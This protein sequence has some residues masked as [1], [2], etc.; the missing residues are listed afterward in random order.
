MPSATHLLRLGPPALHAGQQAGTGGARQPVAG[1]VGVHSSPANAIGTALMHAPALP[2]HHLPRGAC[3]HAAA[4]PSYVTPCDPLP[5]FCTCNAACACKCL[6]LRGCDANRSTAAGTSHAHVPAVAALCVQS[7]FG[8]RVNGSESPLAAWDVAAKVKPGPAR[9][10]AV[11][12]QL[13]AA[14][15]F[16]AGR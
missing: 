11:L 16:L 14:T 8:S 2:T 10:A 9:R 3:T 5:P 7:S 13:G 12:G 4:P 6:D 15:R 1:P